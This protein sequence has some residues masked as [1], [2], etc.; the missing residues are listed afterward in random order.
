KM[1]SNTY[2]FGGPVVPPYLEAVCVVCDIL[3][4]DE[5]DLLSARLQR[6]RE[7]LTAGLTKLGLTVL[8]GQTPI[9]SVLVGDEGGTLKAG[10]FL[11]EQG[12]YVQSVTFPAVPYHAG[13][14]RIQIN[15]NHQPAAIE[16]LLE[17]MGRLQRVIPLPGPDTTR[18]AA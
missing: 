13:V 5:Y 8:C 9:V 15:A 14:L 1:R 4:S 7:Q 3:T 12:F 17:A 18:Q 11:F 10:N 2:I 6:N 16:A